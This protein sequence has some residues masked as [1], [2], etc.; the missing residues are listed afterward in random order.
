MKLT[1]GMSE[2]KIEFEDIDS[3][4]IEQLVRAKMKEIFWLVKLNQKEVK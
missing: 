2:M 1:D 3:T 4:E